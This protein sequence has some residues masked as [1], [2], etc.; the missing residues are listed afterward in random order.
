MR[1]LAPA[2]SCRGKQQASRAG[3]TAMCKRQSDEDLAELI[4]ARLRTA[5]LCD[6]MDEMGLLSQ[7]MAVDGLLLVPPFH[8][9]SGDRGAGGNG[10]VRGRASTA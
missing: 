10:I 6:A 3:T 5:L 2:L 8:V 4:E 9:G 1:V 7:A